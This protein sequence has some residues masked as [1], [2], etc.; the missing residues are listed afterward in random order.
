MKAFYL[1]ALIGFA[2]VIGIVLYCLHLA[3]LVSK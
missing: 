1:S 3:G 2:T